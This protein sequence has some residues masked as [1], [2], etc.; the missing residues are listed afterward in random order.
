[1]GHGVADELLELL[2]DA[3]PV[4]LAQ[5]SEACADIVESKF[6]KAAADRRERGRRSRHEHTLD[7]GRESDGSNVHRA[8]AAVRDECARAEVVASADRD[9][10]ECTLEPGMRD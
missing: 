6:R 9:Q 8:G 4:R 1:R 10:A 7:S 2:L 5:K 3:R